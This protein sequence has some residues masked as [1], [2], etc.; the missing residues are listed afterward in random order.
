MSA[1]L[2]WKMRDEM[3]DEKE[4]RALLEEERE[5]RK[6][7]ETSEMRDD[8]V[9]NKNRQEPN[10]GIRRRPATLKY[11]RVFFQVFVFARMAR[12]EATPG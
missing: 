7:G 6:R 5:R 1:E 11:V 8:P 4:W 9:T 2:R 3:R 12:R 10:L